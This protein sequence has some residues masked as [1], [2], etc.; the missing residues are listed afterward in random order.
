MD[1]RGVGRGLVRFRQLPEA[2]LR[3]RRAS[4]HEIALCGEREI[5]DRSRSAVRRFCSRA[6]HGKRPPIVARGVG[7]V[8]IEI[9]TIS[10]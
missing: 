7:L 8:A 5:R 10:G 1:D 9:A 3:V 6:V 2:D 4:D